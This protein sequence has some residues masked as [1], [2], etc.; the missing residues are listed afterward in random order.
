MPG[1]LDR[2][3]TPHGISAAHW[4]RI[5][6]VWAP[7]QPYLDAIEGM[8]VKQ[9]QELARAVKMHPN[10]VHNVRTYGHANRYL[11]ARLISVLGGDWPDDIA[12]ILGAL[13]EEL[14]TS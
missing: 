3:L 1:H 7:E 10:S 14:R 11:R 12:P 5:S 8:T 4:R 2:L 13:N 9:R 6:R